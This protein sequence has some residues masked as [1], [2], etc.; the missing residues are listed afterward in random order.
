MPSAALRLLLLALCLLAV[1]SGSSAAPKAEPRRIA[2]SFD[3]VPRRPGAFLT[4]D[5]RTQ[6]IISGLSA[7][8]VKAVFFVTTGNFDKPEG[9]GGEA[10]IMMYSGA[11]HLI[12]NHNTLTAGSRKS[13]SRPISRT[14]TGPRPGFATGRAAGP[15]SASPFSTK[16]APTRR[17]AMPSAPGWGHEASP[18]ATSPPTAPTGTWKR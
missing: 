4:P 1:P 17:S 7:A 6:G 14:S 9:K 2:L 11:G 5:Q 12:A 13:R 16:A 15:G 18:T 8:G 3:D 10:R